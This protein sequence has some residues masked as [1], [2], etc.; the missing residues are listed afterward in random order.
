[1]RARFR[2]ALFTALV[3]V[4]PTLISTGPAAD[5]ASRLHPPIVAVGANQS[6]NWSGYN[7]GTLEQGS[8]LFTSIDGDWTVP[9]ASQ[10]RAGEAEYSSTWIGIGGGCIDAT[11]TVTDNTLIQ[12]GTEQDVDSSGRASYSAWWEIIPAPSVTISNFDVHAGDH[13]HASLA[14]GVPGVW[15]MTL[16]DVT[17]GASFTQ[18]IPYASTHATAEW[19]E[20]T[21]VVLS[22]NGDVTVGP[23]PKLSTVNFDLAR[24]NGANANL[25]ASEE[26]QLVNADGSA[27]MTPSAPDAEADGFNDCSY[28][29]T[30]AAPGAKLVVS[31]GN[32][33]AHAPTH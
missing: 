16:T 12:L 25:T 5:A 10:H 3:L 20:E 24:T 17:T 13:M 4:A 32:G 22:D 19:I 28:S 26:M 8:K 9:T 27:L 6:S 1:M 7:Q 18:T 11:C 15:T 33:H 21:P 2:K 29:A 30:C 31:H 23:L 14:E